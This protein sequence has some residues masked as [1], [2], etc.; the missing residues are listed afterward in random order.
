VF[1]EETVVIV[2]RLVTLAQSIGLAVGSLMLLA[3]SGT[4]VSPAAAEV[5]EQGPYSSQE[6]CEAVR[7]SDPN[8]NPAIH[9]C[10]F[11]LQQG[12]WYYYVL[13]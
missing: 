12:A 10:H 2:R 6:E 8:A 5:T 9:H 7:A 4:L 11:R 13:D 3:T 1:K